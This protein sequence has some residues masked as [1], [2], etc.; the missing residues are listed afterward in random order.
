MQC[1]GRQI[2][3][4]KMKQARIEIK[5]WMGTIAHD[6]EGE[7]WY[8]VLVQFNNFQDLDCLLRQVYMMGTSSDRGGVGSFE[9]FVGKWRS[10]D[11]EKQDFAACRVGLSIGHICCLSAA[12]EDGE[13]TFP[14]WGGTAAKTEKPAR[15]ATS[16]NPAKKASG[17]SP[18]RKSANKVVA[19]RTVA[20]TKRKQP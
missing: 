5:G 6:F 12:D 20:R 2:R 9:D 1:L 13:L 17:K 19:K 7:S 3:E 4:V 10:G 14:V 15:S 8:D 11:V 18:A 16:K